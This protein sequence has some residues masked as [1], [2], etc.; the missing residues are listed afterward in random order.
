MFVINWLFVPVRKT[1]HH[2]KVV[3]SPLE[4]KLNVMI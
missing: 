1:N 4:A 3:R 2:L